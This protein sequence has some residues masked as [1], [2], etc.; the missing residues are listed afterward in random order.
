MFLTRDDVKSIADR[1]I[2]RSNADSCKIFVEGSETQS[3][4]FA[5]GSA[6]TNVASAQARLRV[7]SHIGARSGSVSIGGLDAR[8]LERALARSEEIARLMPEDPEFMAPLGPRNYLSGARYDEATAALGL[9]DLAEAA[10]RIIA[11]GRGS[12]VNMFGF[13]GSGRG[14][15]AMATSNGLFAYDRTSFVDLSTTARRRDDL[16][17]GWAG[18]RAFAAAGLDASAIG[19][20]AAEKAAQAAEPVDLEPGRYTVVLEPVAVGELARWLVWMMDARAADEGRSFFSGRGGASRIGEALFDEKITLRSDPQ[21]GVAPEACFGAEGLAQTPRRWIEK[22]VLRELA[23]SRFWARKTERE[24]VPAARSFTLEG[25]GTSIDEMIR[26]TRRGV[27]VTRLWYTNMLDPRSLLLTGLTR[28]GNFLIENGRIVAPA[29]NMRFNDSLAQIFSRVG[30]LGPSA[31]VWLDMGDDAAIS[32]PPM[33]VEE[34]E[35]S[36]KSSGI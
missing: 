2:G 4:R 3:L 35:F 11:A 31:R 19:R 24:S 34:F 13:A 32:A 6:T 5:C 30:A 7:T 10:G 27:L 18:G 9:G 25:G 20:R 28:D 15:E 14:F 8:A 23:R 1:L 33:M 16:W 22:G 21:D 17:S 26:A 12:G 36:S 29:R